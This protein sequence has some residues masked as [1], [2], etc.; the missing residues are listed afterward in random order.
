MRA[1]GEIQVFSP[2]EIWG[3]SAP[4]PETDAAIYLT[5]AFTGLRLGEFLALRWRDVDFAPRRSAF[6]PA[7]PPARSRPEVRQGPLGADGPRRRQALAR[8]GSAR[9]CTGEDDLSS[10]AIVG[11]GRRRARAAY[12]GRCGR[13]PRPLR[14]HDLRHTFGTRMIRR[15]DIAVCR[16]GWATPTSR[17]RCAICTTRHGPATPASGG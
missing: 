14:F 16:S 3:S 10:P 5:A 4:P 11:T 8:L 6:A 12:R 13:R 1:S 17:R 7:T 2:E 9:R 15:A